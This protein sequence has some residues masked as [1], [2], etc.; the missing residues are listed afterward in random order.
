MGVIKTGNPTPT[1]PTELIQGYIDG[2]TGKDAT[3]DNA[4]YKS[5]YDLAI[6]VKE[7]KADPPMWGL[8]V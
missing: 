3:S 4:V 8:N 5:G 2:I 6:L 1:A 7:G